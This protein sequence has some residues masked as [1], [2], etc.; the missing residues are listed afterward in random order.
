M[1]RTALPLA[2]VALS[3]LVLPAAHAQDHEEPFTPRERAQLL[4]G[5]LV[6]RNV[7]RTEGRHHLFGGTSWQLVRAPIERVWRMVSD[8]S[9]YP[10]LIPSLA[11][12]RVVQRRGDEQILLM[13]HEYSIASTRYYARMRFDHAAHAMR[14][15]L[16]ESRPH[17]ELRAGRGFIALSSY[18]GHTIVS[19]GM[20]ADVGAGPVMQIFAPFLNEWLLIPPRC[21]RD[22]LEPGRQPSCGPS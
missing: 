22:E 11:R 12:V 10:R 6:R 14:F 20:L 9:T 5:E 1:T 16:D 3:M 17:D 2:L 13:E 15:A 4:R 18:R 7:S 8:P 21:V 19:W